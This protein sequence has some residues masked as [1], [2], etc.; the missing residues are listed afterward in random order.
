MIEIIALIFLTRHIGQKAAHKG[1]PAGR[2]KLYLVLAWFAFEIPG[3]LL[4]LYLFGKQNLMA[5]SLFAIF[6]AFGGY[7]FIKYRL[8][9]MPGTL[10]DDID[11]IGQ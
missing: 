10:D 6:C 11:R 9:K 7:L 8:D 5:L 1:L 3:F 4:G 2:W